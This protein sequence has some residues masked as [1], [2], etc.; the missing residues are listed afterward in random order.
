MPSVVRA[1]SRGLRLRRG[2]NLWPW[3][4]L[5][6]E[7]PAP[8]TDYDWP[9]FQ[10]GRAIPVRG[11]LATL[12]SAGIDFVRLP[13]DPGPLLAFS[14]AQRERL[15]ADI[16]GAVELCN[17]EALTVI[18]NL[19]PNGATH[20]FNPR[21]LVGDVMAPLFPR[22]LGLVRDVAARLARL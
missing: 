13:V 19:H 8:R 21:N 7:F 12:R 10:A 11:D 22:Y 9:P 14:G 5:T 3:F 6:R 18:V 4:S 16:L 20:H 2:M 15:F 17:D 1:Q